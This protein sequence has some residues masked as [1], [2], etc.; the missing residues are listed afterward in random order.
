MRELP[1]VALP[2]TASVSCGVCPHTSCWAAPFSVTDSATESA[3]CEDPQPPT[4]ARL[5][6]HAAIRRLRAETSIQSMADGLCID[7]PETS[8]GVSSAPSRARSRRRHTAGPRRP[9][10]HNR[11]RASAL[12]RRTMTACFETGP[13]AT[14]CRNVRDAPLTR[15]EGR[16]RRRAEPVGIH[17]EPWVSGS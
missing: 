1:P 7:F 2:A 9:R 17:T 16:A 12:R 11:P 14:L 6:S 5:Q 13:Q 4:L 8:T 3:L 15:E 10:T